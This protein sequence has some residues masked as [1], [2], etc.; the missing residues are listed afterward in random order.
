MSEGIQDSGAVPDASTKYT[1]YG[2]YVYGGELG[3]TGVLVFEK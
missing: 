1:S 3:S 2:V